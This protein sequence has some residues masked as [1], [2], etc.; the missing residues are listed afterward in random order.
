MMKWIVGGAISFLI[1]GL[2]CCLKVASDEDDK[3]KGGDV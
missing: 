3:M 1:F 2:W